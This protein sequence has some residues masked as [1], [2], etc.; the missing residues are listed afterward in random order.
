MYSHRLP[1]S[2]LLPWFQQLPSPAVALHLRVVHFLK[3]REFAHIH[4]PGSNTIE[5]CSTQTFTLPTFFKYPSFRC[6]CSSYIHPSCSETTLYPFAAENPLPKA[7]SSLQNFHRMN[8]RR[9]S[10]H[11]ARKLV[12]NRVVKKIT[13][14]IIPC[15]SPNIL[16]AVSMNIIR[17]NILTISTTVLMTIWINKRILMMTLTTLT[18]TLSQKIEGILCPP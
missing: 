8:N 16:L 17:F 12:A 2:I 5:Q 15:I 4:P 3:N 9:W 11:F 1:L 13:I 7:H 10:M 6:T 14:N 18:M